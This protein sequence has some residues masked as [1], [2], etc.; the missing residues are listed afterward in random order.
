MTNPA[1]RCPAR[2]QQRGFSLIEL[3]VV[4]V[5]L[6]ILSVTALPRLVDL[7]DEAHRSS[8]A[9]TA[10]SFRSAVSLANAACIIRR[11]AG[12]DNL[13]AFGA[14]VVD[15][16]A[17]CLPASTNGNNNLNINAARCL[18]VWNGI[19]LPAPSISTPATDTTEYRAQ[20][21]G[22]TCTYTYRE[23]TDTLRRFTYNAATG[24]V[25]VINP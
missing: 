14:G 10:S 25:N 16:N 13:P 3:I 1:L 4:V 15:F 11:F 23:D 20:G 2:L 8:V 6:A 7:K 19:L 12:L 18:Q 9:A 17:N 22:T 24:A 5:V 21:G